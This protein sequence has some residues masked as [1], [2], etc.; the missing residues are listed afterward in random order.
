MYFPNSRIVNGI[1]TTYSQTRKCT[2]NDIVEILCK[3]HTVISG[4]LHSYILSKVYKVPNIE[5][6]NYN[7][8]K[9]SADKFSNLNNDTAIIPLKTIDYYINHDIRFTSKNWTENDRNDSIVRLHQKTN[10]S[11]EHIQNWGNRQIEEKLI[12]LN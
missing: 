12:S 1:E 2:L 8:Y 4:R 7:N 11:I 9:V 3:S 6:Y 10:I 5:N